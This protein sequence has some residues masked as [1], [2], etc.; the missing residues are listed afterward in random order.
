MKYFL[1]LFAVIVLLSACSNIN[2]IITV[3]DDFKNEKSIR[4]IQELEG[5]SDEKRGGLREV[6]YIVN[7]KTLY[8]KPDG[9]QGKVTAGLILK[10]KARPEELDSLIFIEAD[11][12]KF[13]FISREYAVRHFVNR[14]VS[15]TT[16]AQK[17][18]DNDNEKT[19]TSTKTTTTDHPLQIMKHTIEIPRDMWKQLSQ[20]EQVKFRFYIE[21]EGVTTRFTS[22]DRKKFAEL[23]K[24]I[25]EF[26]KSQHNS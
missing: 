6:D 20:S 2:Q 22:R 26:E 16:L 18:K 25:L 24:I 5:Y 15:T 3:D 10:T 19:S 14:S 23:F 21:D 12:E 4:L 8:L 7:L 17:K 9:Q 1:Y 13:Q 11:G